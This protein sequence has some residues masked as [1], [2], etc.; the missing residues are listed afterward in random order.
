[1]SRRKT[2]LTIETGKRL[3]TES[4]P[5]GNHRRA[6]A[7]PSR[8]S[9]S[10]NGAIS[11]TATVYHDVHDTTEAIDAARAELWKLYANIMAKYDG[12]ARALPGIREALEIC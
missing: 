2:T 5:C 8:T 11:I 1:M 4:A 7:I 6:T 3:R 12:V 9:I 10:E